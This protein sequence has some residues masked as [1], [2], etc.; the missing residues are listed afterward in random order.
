MIVKLKRKSAR[1]RDLTPRLFVFVDRREP[2]DWI[3]EAG[4]E[5]ERYAYPAALDKPGFVEDF[6]DDKPKV[7]ATCWRVVNRR[8]AA[9]RVA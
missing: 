1:Y 2:R 5:G 8:L 4:D 3:C 6:F 9:S 7:V